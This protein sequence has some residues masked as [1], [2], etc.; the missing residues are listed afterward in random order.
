MGGQMVDA[1]S[2]VDPSVMRM[3]AP[4][5]GCWSTGRTAIAACSS[6]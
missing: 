2:G 3:Q 4:W 5:G 6:T 1:F